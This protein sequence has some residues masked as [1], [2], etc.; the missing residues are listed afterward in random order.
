MVSPRLRKEQRNSILITCQYSDLVTASDWLEICFIQSEALPKYGQW[1][2]M[3]MEF[4]CSFFR[5]HFAMKPPVA[6][7]NVCAF[8]SG[9]K[10]PAD[11]ANGAPSVVGGVPEPSVNDI[12][13]LLKHQGTEWCVWSK[14][15]PLFSHS[16]RCIP[17]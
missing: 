3:G 1:H 4:L 15:H 12:E 7:R 10:L 17:K 5:R 13:R 9:Y 2:A 14:Q 11:H 16:S 8:F 6:S